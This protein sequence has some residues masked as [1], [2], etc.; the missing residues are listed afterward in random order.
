MNEFYKKLKKEKKQKTKNSRARKKFSSKVCVAVIDSG[1]GGLAVLKKLKKQLPRV[2]Y[3]CVSDSENMPYG[4][5]SDKRI[6]ALCEKNCKLALSRGA[7]I[8]FVACNTMASVGK[9]VFLN[10]GV[11]CFFVEPE[12]EKINEKWSKGLICAIFCTEATARRIKPFFKNESLSSCVYSQKT[13]AKEIENKVLNKESSFCPQIEFKGFA[14]NVN[15]VFLCCTHY[16]HAASIFK[17]KFKNAILFDGTKKPIADLKEYFF[18][19][20]DLKAE[21]GGVIKGKIKFVGSGRKKMRA[22]YYGD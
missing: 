9:S 21:N 10:F 13:L 18:N 17:A 6:L 16:I 3:L 4:E 2:D 14:D 11:P 20:G 22:A 15:A 12:L 5:K 8:F 19:S 1:A 7:T